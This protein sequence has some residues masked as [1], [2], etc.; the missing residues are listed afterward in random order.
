MSLR[1]KKRY[2]PFLIIIIIAGLVWLS[3]I[4]EY[5]SIESLKRN[6]VFL[7]EYV[8]KNYIFSIG[9]FVSI[10]ITMTALSIPV[11]SFLTL[12]AGFLYGIYVGLA[13][14]MLSASVGSTIF[15]FSAK[16][17]TK[18]LVPDIKVKWLNRMRRGFNENSFSY[19]LSLRLLPVFPFWMVNVGA[20]IFQIPLRHFFFATLIGIIPGSFIIITIGANIGEI[21][22]TESFNLYDYVTIEKILLLTLMG[23][24]VLAPKIG[25]LLWKRK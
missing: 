18:K 16:I 13:V 21:L 1:I 12:T 24:A 9:I 7:N 19:M 22:E 17:A 5:I 3:G 4:Y 11:A 15:L 23:V 14:V 8:E 20:A 25:Q 10:Y 2:L 6:Q